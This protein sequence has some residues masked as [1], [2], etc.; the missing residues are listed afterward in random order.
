MSIWSKLPTDIVQHIYEFD[1]TYK[2]KFDESLNFIEHAFPTCCCDGGKKERYR[3]HYDITQF[4]FHFGIG[5]GDV[6]MRAQNT[7]QEILIKMEIKPN[8]TGEIWNTLYRVMK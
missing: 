5:N 8:I 2:E 1:S 6:E 3:H 7:I 4:G